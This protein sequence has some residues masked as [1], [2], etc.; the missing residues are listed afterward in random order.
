MTSLYFVAIPR[1][2]DTHIQNKAPGPPQ[3]MAMATPAMFP[4]PTVAE[5]AVERAWKCETSPGSS[6]SSYFPE[7]TARPCPIFRSEEHTSELQSRPHLVC[8]LLLEKKN[9]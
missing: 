8:R 6:G 2:A 9:H 1:S 3:C 5:S 7:V 4:T